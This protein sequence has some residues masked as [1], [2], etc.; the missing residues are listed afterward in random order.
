M[1]RIDVPALARLAAQ[2]RKDTADANNPAWYKN[3]IMTSIAEHIERSIGAPQMQQTFEEG[4]RE[5]V[6]LYPGGPAERL[7]FNS[8]VKW[9]LEQM[10]APLQK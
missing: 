10:T 2:I 1:D 5:A 8:G 4:T 9:C 7:A 3:G 6:K